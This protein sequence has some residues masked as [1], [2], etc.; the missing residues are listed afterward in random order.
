MK[1]LAYLHAIALLM[2]DAAEGGT[3]VDPFDTNVNDIDTSRPRLPAGLYDLKIK[4][5]VKKAP[6]SGE[7]QQ[8]EIE[9]MTTMDHQSTEKELIKA[10]TFSLY[11]YIGLNELP[12]RESKPDAQ[13]KT[14]TLKARTREDIAADIAVVCKSAR[15]S[16][17][18][19]DVIETPAQLEGQLVTCKVAI[20]AETPQFPES[21][22]IQS[23]VV[24]K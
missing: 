22:R 13:G 10:G 3:V 9:L 21:N 8:L 4:K 18:V 2:A 16:V 7:G 12:E 23:F 14:K 5:V 11:H 20:N 24:K 15:M 6:K 1:K 19:K 17:K